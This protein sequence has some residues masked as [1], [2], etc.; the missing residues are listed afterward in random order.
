MNAIEVYILEEE[1]TNQ[2]CGACPGG[3][4]KDDDLLL[5]EGA[6]ID[7]HTAISSSSSSNNNRGSSSSS[8]HETFLPVGHTT[9]MQPI[10]FGDGMDYAECHLYYQ[11]REAQTKGGVLRR[12][13]R[14]DN[15]TAAPSIGTT[16]RRL[17]DWNNH[18]GSALKAAA[19]T[20]KPGASVA[21]PKKVVK[22]ILRY[23]NNKPKKLQQHHTESRTS[24]LGFDEDPC[25]P[26]KIVNN[27]LRKSS[28]LLRRCSFSEYPADLVFD[29]RGPDAC[30]DGS[31]NGD[32]NCSAHH[33]RSQSVRH[34]IGGPSRCSQPERPRVSFHDR[35][36]VHTIDPVADIPYETRRKLWMTKLEMLQALRDAALRQ[37][38]EERARQSA[39]FARLFPM[40]DDD[41]D[42]DDDYNEVDCPAFDFF[43][44]EELDDEDEYMGGISTVQDEQPMGF[45]SLIVS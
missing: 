8:Y 17:S 12:Q 4:E 15:T 35:V 29:A 28:A 3:C 21:D 42:D 14:D 7:H 45:A 32:E 13:R 23:N 5:V 19:A 6:K 43:N 38:E 36:E 18:D 31:D 10:I 30:G 41:D 1:G 40:E 11:T 44:Q 20:N 9:F 24:T 16:M 25:S 39:E 2:A 26:R 33:R 34:I 22:P 37:W 27:S